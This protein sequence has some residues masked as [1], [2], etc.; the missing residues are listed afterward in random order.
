MLGVRIPPLTTDL[1]VVLIDVDRF[2]VLGGKVVGLI[3]GFV[4]GAK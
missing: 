3:V 4:V 1:F 2:V